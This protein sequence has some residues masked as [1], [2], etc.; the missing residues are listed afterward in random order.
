MIGVISFFGVLVA[1]GTLVDIVVNIL[2]LEEEVFSEKAIQMLQ[3]FSLYSNT[4]KLFNCPD[5]GKEG[6][7]DC[8]HGIRFISMAWVVVGHGYSMFQS[9]QIFSSNWL[10]AINGFMSSGA[11]ALVVNEW[12]SVDSFFLLGA[13]LLSYLTL[14]E[15]DRTKGGNIRF[16]SMFFIHRYIRLT[17]L[18]AIVLG[19]SSTLVKF[20]A[21]G[22]QSGTIE[23]GVNACKETWWTNLLYVNN[24][25]WVNEN[26]F[27]CLGQ[28]WYLANDMQFFLT[29]PIIIFALWKHRTIG[30]SLLATLLVSFTVIPT[31]LGFVNN[32]G[33]STQILAGG[34]PNMEGYF[35]QFYVV[36]WCRYQPYLVGLGL[37]YLLHRLRETPRLPI[38]PIALTWIWVLAALTGCLVVY[39]LVPYQK[40]STL[41]A[42]TTERALYGGLHRLAW[43]LALAWVILACVKGRGGPVNSILSWSAWIPLARMSYATYLVHIT[44]MQVVNSYDSYRVKVTHVLIIYYLIFVLCISLAISYA[45]IMLFEAP[46]VHLEKLVYYFLGVG[47]LPNAKI[48]KTE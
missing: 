1:S 33:F 19:L 5:P 23:Y 31:V 22:V 42:S 35:D 18:Y 26:S 14:K 41:L 27:N 36:P 8:I 30:L 3:G 43:A 9:G 39:G 29:S 37:G 47:K 2:H 15:L 10:S 40:D 25:K 34:N 20:F 32:W 6:S 24:L 12:V 7:L 16:W 4:I 38:N 28:T 48:V 11:F 46:L 17:G 21:T 44:V 45:L 13:T